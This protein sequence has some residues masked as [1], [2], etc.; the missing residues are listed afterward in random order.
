MPDYHF[1]G[2]PSL[3]PVECN[4]QEQKSSGRTGKVMLKHK[5]ARAKGQWQNWKCNAQ[6]QRGSGRTGNVMLKNK[7]ARAKGQW[8]NLRYLYSAMISWK[9]TLIVM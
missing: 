1:V 5:G 9:Q 3:N 4:A 8:Q 7:G 6:E 2:A